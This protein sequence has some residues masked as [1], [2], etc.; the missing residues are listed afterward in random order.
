MVSSPSK[1]Q[2]QPGLI[3]LTLIASAFIAFLNETALNV[4]L[5]NFMN[6]FNVSVSTVQWLTT[7]FMLVMTIVIPVTAFINQ[8][9]TTRQI[10]FTAMSLLLAGTLVSGLAPNFSVLLAGRLLQAA[11]TCTL[12]S[13]MTITMLLLTPPH[14]RGTAMGIVGLVLLFAPALSPSLAGF[15]LYSFSWRWLFLGMVPFIL[16]FMVLANKTLTNVTETS[17][18]RIDWLSFFLSTI[19][20]GGILYG[21][22]SLGH[23]GIGSANVLFPLGAGILFLVMFAWR[24][25]HLDD[26]FL[27]L[28][29]FTYPMFTLGVLLVIFDIMTA[30]A[31]ALLTPMFLQEVFG[32]STFAVGLA[33]LP[34][35]LLNGIV[36]PLIGRIFDKVGPKPLVIPG[37]L[38]ML[39]VSW[40]FS[41]VSASTSLSIF[42]LMYCGIML[43]VTLVMAPAQTNGLNQLPRSLYPHGTAIMSTL[44]QLG[45]GLGTAIFVSIMSLYQQHYL[46]QAAP[47]SEDVTKAA[48]TYGFNQAFFYC[49]LLLI[50]V[51]AMTLFIKRPLLPESAA[52]SSEELTRNVG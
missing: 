27:D 2:I 30:F 47:F 29:V 42:I 48:F 22:S 23:T 3:K 37:L 26:P 5:A 38:L 32:L 9:F 14:Q 51:L 36:S 10:F 43:G 20:F 12:M 4:A 33:L 16:A 17:K 28:K 18:G 11:A 40:L 45:G 19:A 34:G 49:A 7:G 41:G 44:Q 50:A 8:R 21:L 6:I 25:L 35:G 39:I 52:K 24:Q 13:L 31:V 1:A 15:I 46:A